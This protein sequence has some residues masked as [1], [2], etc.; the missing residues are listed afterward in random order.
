M[1]EQT[2]NLSESNV[3]N[4]PTPLN[5]L[6]GDIKSNVESMFGEGSQNYVK[7]DSE[8]NT[9]V[10]KVFKDGVCVFNGYSVADV[11]LTQEQKGNDYIINSA[12]EAV[13]YWIADG[14]PKGK[15]LNYDKE[16]KEDGVRSVA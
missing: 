5:Q 4:I 13:G 14:E 9:L 6:C 11:N 16:E 2:T 8:N 1:L 7:V 3:E 10:V 12:K 15:N